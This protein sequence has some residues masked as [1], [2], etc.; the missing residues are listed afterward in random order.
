[1]KKHYKIDSAGFFNSIDLICKDYEKAKNKA[2]C[3]MDNLKKIDIE[4]RE[5]KI[6]KS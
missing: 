3:A 2:F 4:V 5:R 6:K 1:M